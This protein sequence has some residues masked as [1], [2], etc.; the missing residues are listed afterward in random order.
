MSSPV[1]VMHAEQPIVSLIPTMSLPG[2][3]QLP[4][5]NDAKKVVG[6]ITQAQLI[7]ALFQQTLTDTRNRL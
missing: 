4:I 3:R 7:N 2:F 5:V 6:M 1:T